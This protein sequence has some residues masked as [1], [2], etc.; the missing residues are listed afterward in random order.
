MEKRKF[1]KTDMNVSV[2]GFGGAEI[3]SLDPKNTSD[4]TVEQLLGRALDAGLNVIDTAECYENSEELIGNAVSH[5]RDDYYLF[6][7][8]GHPAGFNLEEWDPKLLTLSIERSL[9]RLKTDHIDLIHLH[10]CSEEVLK[11]GD[12]IE[13]LQKAKEAGKTRY[14]GYSGENEAA[15]Y[16]VNTGVFDSLQTSINIADQR[17][18]DLILPEARKQGMG[19]IAKRPLA[20]VAWGSGLNPPDNNYAQEYWER[21][22]KLDY[23]FL[24]GDLNDAVATALRFTL[25]IPDVCTAIVGTSNP[26]RWLQNIRYLEKGPLAAGI[27][28]EIREQWS[29]VFEE[30][31]IGQV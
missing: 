17:G 12:V 21:L 27:I 14:I 24:V 9:Q 31:W 22:R 29:K 20:N 16:A 15:L 26:D 2:L 30:N 11:R 23:N 13:V 10:S 25:S 6:T 5:R 8:C 28:R 7:K 19:I 3:G 18:I 4:K 1:G